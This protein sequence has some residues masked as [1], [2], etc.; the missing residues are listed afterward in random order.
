MNSDD[1][2]LVDRRPLR[3]F[4]TVAPPS[5]DWSY[6]FYR[7]AQNGRFRSLWYAMV[8]VWRVWRIQ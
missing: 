4:R 8:R 2:D 6:G 1:I 5:S 7:R 3:T